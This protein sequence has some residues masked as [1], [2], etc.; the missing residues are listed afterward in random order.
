MVM[1]TI[2]IHANAA[3]AFWSFIRIIRIKF[4]GWHYVNCG[5]IK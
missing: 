1:Q 4:A 3:N 5:I 2:R